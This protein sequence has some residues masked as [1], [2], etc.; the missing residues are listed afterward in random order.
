MNIE[1]VTGCSEFAHVPL[2]VV[3]AFADGTLTAS[4]AMLT[5]ETAVR[6]SALVIAGELRREPGSQLQLYDFSVAFHR[7]I[8]LVA[9]GP[10]AP[11]SERAFRAALGVAAQALAEGPAR[12]AVVTLT[13]VEVAGR[14]L[15]WRIQLA[16]RLLTDARYR[17]TLSEGPARRRYTADGEADRVSLVLP[18]AV[19]EGH[20]LAVRRGLAVAEGV[21]VARDLANAPP[22]VC[23]PAFLAEV[24]S[25]IGVR[26]SMEVEVFER[27]DLASL[28]MEALLAVGEDERAPCN[29]VVMRYRGGAPAARPV[30][31][32]GQGLTSEPGGGAAP[33]EG[34]RRDP[35]LDMSGAAAVLGTMWGVASL[36]MPINLLGLVPAAAVRGGMSPARLGGVVR[37]MSGQTIE[38]LSPDT[39]GLLI[40]CDALSYAQH[41]KPACLID[42]AASSGAATLP[43]GAYASGFLAN[44]AALAQELLASG[45]EAADRAWQLPLWEDCE[46]ELASAVADMASSAGP[47][48]EPVTS[49]CFLLRFAGDTRWAH[50]D[51]TGTARR[52]GERWAATGRPVP[53]LMTFLARRAA[54]SRQAAATRRDGEPGTPRRRTV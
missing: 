40:L 8:L 22:G 18:C 11:L 17:F 45:L 24:A 26:F 35:R 32:V 34:G 43:L 30:V 14:N 49:A 20:A 13:A 52:D 53:L 27:D 36:Q 33:G 50:L 16:A 2:L 4:A 3:G 39:A 21:A 7:R 37:S 42:V 6:L 5:E 51:I 12:G 44:D 38:I 46:A 47:L 15:E 19:E 28:G 31:L 1:L 25:A 10:G 23:T 9:L 54:R 29:L 48:A 41:F